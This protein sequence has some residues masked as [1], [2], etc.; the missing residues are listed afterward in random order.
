MRV[1]HL[2]RGRGGVDEV[3]RLL[4]HPLL[5]VELDVLLV[6]PAA[7]VRLPHGR[8]VVRQVRVAVVAKVFRHLDDCNF[9]AKFVKCFSADFGLL[10]MALSGQIFGRR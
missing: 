8:G 7:A 1:A 2:E 10:F 4:L 5:V 9:C 3:L 6:L